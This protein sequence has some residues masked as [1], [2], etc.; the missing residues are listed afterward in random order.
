MVDR[1]MI[2]AAERS[3]AIHRE[4]VLRTYLQ[5]MPAWAV[6]RIV[7]SPRHVC[8]RALRRLMPRKR[9]VLRHAAL[10]GCDSNLNEAFHSVRQAR[11][12]RRVRHVRHV[13]YL[14]RGL[15]SRVR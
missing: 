9:L 1:L 12:I 6:H 10:N 11:R 14:F 5:R 4:R 15:G 8:K 7:Q 3:T 13:R 2:R